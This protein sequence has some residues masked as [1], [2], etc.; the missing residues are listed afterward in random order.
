MASPRIVS[1][2]PRLCLPLIQFASHLRTGI[3]GPRN[4]AE[5]HILQHPANP[6]E[7]T[8][9][10]TASDKIWARGYAPICNIVVHSF[11]ADDGLTHANFDDAFM[12]LDADDVLRMKETAVPTNNR[13]WRLGFEADCENWFNTEVANVT[14]AA[15][16]RYPGVIQAS[17]CKP[18]SSQ[19]I[20][21]NIDS[22]FSIKFAGK[23]APLV[24]GEMKRN[25]IS[26]TAWQSGFILGQ[27]SQ[28]KLSQ[29]LR[30][31]ACKYEC[32][33]VFCFDGS[34]LLLLQFRALRAKD[35]ED[36]RCWVDC[37][38]LP[39]ATS[40]CT[41]RYAL[42]RLLVQGWRRYQAEL[43]GPDFTV[44]GLAPCFREFFT[45]QPIWGVEEGNFR[46]H[47]GGYQRSVDA[48]TGALIWTHKELP[49]EMET[50]AFW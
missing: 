1:R 33:Q 10:T 14:L 2:F 12:R 36:V 44:G 47:P 21:E 30:G 22:T 23:R 8:K 18:L 35:L 13:H 4:T 3:L 38:V 24:I 32:P 26:A 45:G 15:W 39:R 20:P 37:W 17:H 9:H 7:E 41:L 16:K 11:V 46:A 25:L 19:S 5:H 43:A 40:S 48:T 28:M 34:T 27:A 42:Y 50:G 29:E 6:V 49:T 31:Y